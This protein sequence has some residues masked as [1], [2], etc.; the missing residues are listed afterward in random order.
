[1][2]LIK[3]WKTSYLCLITC[4]YAKKPIKTS[5]ASIMG[6]KILDYSYDPEAKQQINGKH[7]L[8]LALQIIS[9]NDNKP[10]FHFHLQM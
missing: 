1:M 6:N 10:D 5:Q 8:S 3:E 7:F 2:V 4:L 9:I